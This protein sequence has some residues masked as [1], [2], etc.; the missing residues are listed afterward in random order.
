MIRGGSVL[1][2]DGTFRACDIEIGDGLVASVTPAGQGPRAD[3]HRRAGVDARG[4]TVLPGLVDLHTHGI[5][6]MLA[7]E[8]DL[9]EY[10]R[11]EA[12]YGVTR[13]CATLFGPPERLEASMRRHRA[14]TEELR[15]TPQ[16]WGF[17][18]ESP[19][20][21]KAG[22]GVSGDITRITAETTERLMEAGGG[23]IRIWDMSP[24]LAGA[25]ELVRLL[26]AQ[27]ILTSI[28]HTKASIAQ[29]R[30]AVDGGTRLVT[31]LFDTFDL[32]DYPEPGVYPEGLVDYILVE[33]RL[34]AEIIA[35]GTHV[36]PL[37]VEKA[38]RCKGAERICF[39]TDSNV[40][41]GLP[42][43]RR[44]LPG[45]G[46]TVEIRGPND[47]VRLVDRNGE[48]SGS[49][50]T[51]LD[52]LRNAVRLFGRD[53]ATASRLCSTTPARLLG[54]NAGEIEVG[55]DADLILLDGDMNLRRTIVRGST[56][57]SAE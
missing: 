10:A 1:L 7:L 33:D 8:G 12:E 3:G 23:L 16:V 39:I 55:R 30:A 43:G 42:P 31:H 5:R 25:P 11:I 29:A 49:A 32:P 56:A 13:F 15:L 21:A 50:L 40:G 51:Q 54:L 34:T 20:L 47:G 53:L 6:E 37:L 22:G 36:K 45:R 38:L 4:L 44:V 52:A 2:P 9:A 41:A 14:E 35:D 48:L 17:R 46:E 24:D 28:A 27:G 18:L 26:A 19:Y 57:W